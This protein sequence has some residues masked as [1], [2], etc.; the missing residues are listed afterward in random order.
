MRFNRNTLIIFV[1]I[2]IIG[3]MSIALGRNATKKPVTYPSADFISTTIT[4]VP[5]SEVWE[6]VKGLR[7]DGGYTLF[8]FTF[9]EDGQITIR[10]VGG[11]IGEPIP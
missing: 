1:L 10:A 7:A 2:V 11:L 3:T 6:T 4:D 8:S 5:Q 9:E